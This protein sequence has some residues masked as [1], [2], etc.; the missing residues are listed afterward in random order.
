M[1]KRKKK[2][3]K[4][5]KKTKRSRAPKVDSYCVTSKVKAAV[6]AGGCN[7]GSDSIGAVNML[8]HWYIDQACKRAAANGRKTVRPH[9]FLVG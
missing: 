2:A 4:K 3:S 5:K 7:F 6:K 8:V 9:D 1:A